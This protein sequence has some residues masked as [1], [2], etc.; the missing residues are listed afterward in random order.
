[1]DTPKW[2]VLPTTILCFA[3]AVMVFLIAVGG[4]S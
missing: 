2:Y 1:M 4:F 3:V